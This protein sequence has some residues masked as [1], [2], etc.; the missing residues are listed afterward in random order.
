MRLTK[1]LVFGVAVLTA[2]AASAAIV[3]GQPNGGEPP[4]YEIYNDLYGTA[5]TGNDDAAF[6]ALQSTSETITLGDDV[7]SLSFDALW[8]QAWLESTVGYYTPGDPGSATPVIGPFDNTGPNGGQGPVTMD[9]VVVDA[10]GLDEIGF[11]LHAES[12]T[13]PATFFNWYSEAALN[14]GEVHVLILETGIADTYLLCFE[15][16]P[17]E[18]LVEGNA[19]QLDLGDQDYQ[20]ILVQVTLNRTVVPEPSS[21]VLLGLGLA[22]VAYRR[23]RIRA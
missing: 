20:D 15:D 9:P 21:L 18:F 19:K 8:R 7:E 10:T 17:Y 4:L 2:M 3:P 11:Y 14:G 1:H 6:L 13:D 16:L 23:I 5:F 12:P 22:A